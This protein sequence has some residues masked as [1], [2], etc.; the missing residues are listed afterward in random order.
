MQKAARLDA[1]YRGEGNF[2]G[3]VRFFNAAVESVRDGDR[4]R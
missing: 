1:N 4:V 3:I 2:L